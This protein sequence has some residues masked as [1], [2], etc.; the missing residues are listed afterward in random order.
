[1][2]EV[3]FLI[4]KFL[5]NQIDAPYFKKEFMAWWNENCL[6]SIPTSFNLNASQILNDFFSDVEAYTSE[7][8]LV[9]QYGNIDEQ[10]LRVC[11]TNTLNLLIK[12]KTRHEDF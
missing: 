9:G 12:E 1:M 6:L 7:Q 2:E 4:Q 5:A 8:S 3:I 10:E 11:A